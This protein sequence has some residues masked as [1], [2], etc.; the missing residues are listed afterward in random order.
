MRTRILAT[1]LTLGV[2]GCAGGM[3]VTA[4]TPELVFIEPGIQ[5]VVDSDV[6]VFYTD[7][8]Y[9]RF[10]GNVW[11]RSHIASGGWIRYDAPPQHLRRIERPQQYVHYR[12]TDRGP[13]VRDHRSP[14]P[15]PVVHDRQ[16]PPPVVRDHQPPPD[17]QDRDDGNRGKDKGKDKDKDKDKDRDEHRKGPH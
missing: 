3:S 12:P 13:V 2:F 10:E 5:V 11:Y 1:A 15:A 14:A 17:R 16:P 9:W 7:N 4:T 8:F 6:P